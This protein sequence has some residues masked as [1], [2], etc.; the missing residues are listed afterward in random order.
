MRAHAADY[1]YMPGL[2][3]TGAGAVGRRPLCHALCLLLPS[4]IA[5]CAFLLLLALNASHDCL[6]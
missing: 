4:L 5:S 2:R 3:R 6:S 1:D